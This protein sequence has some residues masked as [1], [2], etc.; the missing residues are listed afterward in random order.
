MPGRQWARKTEP[1]KRKICAHAQRSKNM[2]E[3]AAL[4]FVLLNYKVFMHADPWKSP[5]TVNLL[6]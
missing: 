1:P 2:I 3:Q 5:E 4:S 6:P